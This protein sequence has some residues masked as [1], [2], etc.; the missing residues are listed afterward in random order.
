[1]NQ[2]IKLSIPLLAVLLLFASCDAGKADTD[3]VNY[4]AVKI[5][6]Q[7][8]WSI[9]N[10]NTGDYLYKNEFKNKPSVIVDDRFFVEKDLNNGY[11]CY[12]VKDISKALNND[13]YVGVTYFSDGVALVTKKNDPIT[14]INTAGKEV[15]VLE[16][17]V[18]GALP[19]SNG[20]A[21]IQNNKGKCGVIDTKGDLVIKADY[22]AIANYSVDGYAVTVKKQNDTIYEFSI[23]DKVGQ[24]TFTFTNE[25]YEP[26]GG[27]VNGVMPVKKNDKVVYI[28]KDGNRVL[29]AQAYNNINEVYGM[30]E[31]VTAYASE[32]GLF[33]VMSR[34][35]E[36]LIRDKYDVLYPLKNGT[37]IAMRNDKVGIV[38][39]NDNVL[40]DFEYESIAKLKKN[41]FLV[42]ERDNSFTIVDENNHEICK[43]SFSDVS[44]SFTNEAAFSDASTR[45]SEFSKE[46]VKTFTVN[47]VTFKMNIVEGGTFIMGSTAKEDEMPPHE[48][49][50]NTFYIGE[51]E[52]TQELWSTVMGN[53]PSKLRGTQLPVTNVTWHDCQNFISRL[54]SITGEQFRL[55]TEAEWEFAAKGGIYSAGYK[56]SGSNVLDDVA[57]NYYNSG[58]DVILDQTNGWN[59]HDAVCNN[60]R[61]HPAASKRPNELGLYDMSGNV[62]EWCQDW[63]SPNY[64]SNSSADNPMGPNAGTERVLRGGGWQ[65]DQGG[66]TTTLRSKLAPSKNW[67]DTGLRLAL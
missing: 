16:K 47:G 22:E 24:K 62:W 56:F 55:P 30:Y 1:M 52:V 2:F 64:Y 66:A 65:D 40:I 60:Y 14:I 41:R 13:A 17:D 53:N 59:Y 58:D 21:I 51:T 23:V 67:P 39:K 48:V 35:G 9:I 54:N 37:F 43:D 46:T 50:V 19:F 26:L 12:D 31:G 38:D 63:Y 10:V 36:K 7:E 32:D 11:E 49:S 33:G 44:F 5:A 4:L 3:E 8:N 28:D 45:L 61:P 18:V 42:K 29:D 25:K 15:K 20:F 34:E 27:M 6:G 57:W